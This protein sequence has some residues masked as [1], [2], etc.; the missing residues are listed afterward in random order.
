MLTFVGV[1][2]NPTLNPDSSSL[3]LKEATYEVT[4]ELLLLQGRFPCS[5]LN[6]LCV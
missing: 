6:L 5:S 1:F 2:F 4:H 3:V